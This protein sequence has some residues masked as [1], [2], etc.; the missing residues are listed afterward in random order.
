MLCAYSCN[1]GSANA[2]VLPLPVSAPPI[3]FFPAMIGGIHCIVKI[4]ADECISLQNRH[5][6]IKQTLDC[7]GVGFSNC[8]P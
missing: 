4:F 3:T 6:S 2:A 1:T 8:I 5:H 7:I